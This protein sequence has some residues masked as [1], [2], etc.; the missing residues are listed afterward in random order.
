MCMYRLSYGKYLFL[1]TAIFP[2]IEVFPYDK[3]PEK[4]HLYDRI[5]LKMICKNTAQVRKPA[6]VYEKIASELG[7]GIGFRWVL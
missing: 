3:I 4:Y 7:L 1:E 2:M 6:E 5:P